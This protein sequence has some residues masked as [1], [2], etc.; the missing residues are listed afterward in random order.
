VF[1]DD[2]LRVLDVATI[3]PRRLSRHVRG[4][5]CCFELAAGRAAAAA[6]GRGV[7]LSLGRSP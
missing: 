2:Q 4:S 7:R 5:A 3:P 1:C 6:V